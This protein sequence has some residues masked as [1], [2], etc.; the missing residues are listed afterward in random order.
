M[1]VKRTN[2]DTAST[3]RLSQ[4][5]AAVSARPL[6]RRSFLRASGLTVGGLA[7]L[8]TLGAGMTRLVEAAGFTDMS[9]PIEIRTNICTNC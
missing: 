9:Q 8:G 4:M 3:G 5:A 2:G 1:L 6:D 7:A